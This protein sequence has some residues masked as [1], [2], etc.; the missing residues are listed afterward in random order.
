MNREQE[1]GYFERKAMTMSI[2]DKYLTD[3]AEHEI[4]ISQEC[5]ERVLETDITRSETL[6]YFSLSMS[7][8]CRC[9]NA[10]ILFDVNACCLSNG[11]DVSDE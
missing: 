9:L 1:E 11:S 5:K 4:N 7:C 6:T 8:L 10:W 3:G 2:V